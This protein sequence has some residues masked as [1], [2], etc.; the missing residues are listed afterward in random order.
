MAWKLYQDH[1]SFVIETVLTVESPLKGS[2]MRN[3]A[4]SWTSWCMHKQSCCRWFK[5]SSRPCDVTAIRAMN[6][7]MVW[8]WNVVRHVLISPSLGCQPWHPSRKWTNIPRITKLTP[9]LYHIEEKY[10]TIFLIRT[11]AASQIHC[12]CLYINILA[13]FFRLFD[14]NWIFWNQV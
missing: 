13:P 2:V 11:S 9:I 8:E 10:I 6:L 3:F 4:V 1:R 7:R 14:I 5:T 12:K